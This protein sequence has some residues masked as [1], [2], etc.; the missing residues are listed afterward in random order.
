MIIKVVIVIQSLVNKLNRYLLIKNY[1]LSFLFPFILASSSINI[2]D[3][4]SN[5]L[6]IFYSI[7][8]Y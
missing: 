5:E 7:F 3:N 6:N 2:E 8:F 4:A 1:N